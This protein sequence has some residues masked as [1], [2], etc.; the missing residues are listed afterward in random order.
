MG[1][2]SAVAAVDVNE[3]Q[4]T[5]TTTTTNNNESP[6]SN[7]NNRG[8]HIVNSK[9]RTAEKTGVLNLSDLDL[10]SNSPTWNRLIE[11]ELIV[12]ITSVD[13]SNNQLKVLPVEIHGLINM[14]TLTC[15][16]SNLQSTQ[17]MTTLIQ[18]TTLRLHNNDLEE[19]K[20][21]PLPHTI[22]HLYLSFNHFKVPPPLVLF[23]PAVIHLDLSGNRLSSVEGL[24]AMGTLVEVNLDDNLLQELPIA[25]AALVN[26]KHLSLKVNQF[27]AL[28]PSQ[29]QQ[30][31]IPKAIFEETQLEKLE[32]K[33]NPLTNRELMS[34]EGVQSFIQRSKRLKDRRSFSGGSFPDHSLSGLD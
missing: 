34:F 5:A 6:S 30:Q 19:H 28:S 29:P 15:N 4:P 20:M 24:E 32:L 7:N 31:S 27:R 2:T 10:K 8:K 13:I 1:N 17:D 23:L 26:L 33:G 14:K 22:T 25:L 16:D 11:P 3:T 18:L 21:G 12:K 9:F